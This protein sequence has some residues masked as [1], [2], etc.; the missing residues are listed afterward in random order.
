MRAD[1]EW[2]ISAVKD[3]STEMWWSAAEALFLS[4]PDNVPESIHF[5]LDPTWQ[6]RE[7]VATKH[8]IK[9]VQAWAT[10]IHGWNS[11]KSPLEFLKI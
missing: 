7:V 8:D 1:P 6:E 2:V 4:N 10:G 3:D 5:M 9:A 11:R